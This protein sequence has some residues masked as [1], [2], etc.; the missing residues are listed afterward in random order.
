VKLSPESLRKPEQP[1]ERLGD[2]GAVCQGPQGGAITVHHDRLCGPHPGNVR[3]AAGQGNPGPVIGVGGSDDRGG[4]AILA[5]GLDQQILA[6]ILSR[7]YCQNGFRKGVD[8]RIGSRE[9]VS[10]ARR[11]S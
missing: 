2:V 6:G 1:D 7:E 4:E 11:R 9:G 3:P 5:V 10:G 8:S